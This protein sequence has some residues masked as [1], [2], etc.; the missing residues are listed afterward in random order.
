[1]QSV[2]ETTLTE[3][4]V[5]CAEALDNFPTEAFRRCT[6]KLY[7]MKNSAASYIYS[8]DCCKDEAIAVIA[9]AK[10]NAIAALHQTTTTTPLTVD[11]TADTLS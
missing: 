4:N 8:I 11:A 2:Q 1:M 5:H 6:M 10:D 3:F 7:H 9:H